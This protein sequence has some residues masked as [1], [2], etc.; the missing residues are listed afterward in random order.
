M[1]TGNRS[2][3]DLLRAEHLLLTSKYTEL[4]KNFDLLQSSAGSKSSSN[5]LASQLIQLSNDLYINP[6]YSD[7]TYEVEGKTYRGHKFV[8]SVRTHYFADLENKNKIEFSELSSNVFDLVFKWMYTDVLDETNDASLLKIGEFSSKYKLESLQEL[9]ELLLTTRLD[10]SNC[11]PIFEFADKEG[12]A[13]LRDDCASLVAARW[14]DF[15]KDHFSSLSATL[16]FRL[17]KG[18]STNVLNSIIELEREDVLFLFFIENDSKL[19]TLLNDTTHACSALELSVTLKSFTIAK[20]L[21]D[22]GADVNLFYPSTNE[23]LLNR[24][25]ISGNVEACV[26]LVENSVSLKPSNTSCPSPLQTI[27]ISNVTEELLEWGL[28][29][30]STSDVNFTSD[31][32]KLHKRSALGLACLNENIL[33]ERFIVALLENGADPNVIDDKSECCLWH[34]LVAPPKLSV[35]QKLIDKGANVDVH[36]HSDPLL[37]HLLSDLQSYEFLLSNGAKINICDKKGSY[38]IHQIVELFKTNKD[39]GKQLLLSTLTHQLNCNVLNENNETPIHLAVQT[40]VEAVEILQKLG[41][42]ID[43]ALVDKNDRSVLKLSLESKKFDC[44]EIILAGGA[45]IDETNK[46]G[47]NLLLQS[48]KNGLDDVCVFLLAHKANHNIRDSSGASCLEVALSQGME[49]TVKALCGVGV[50]VNERSVVGNGFGVLTR[51]ISTENF[52]CASLLVSFGC[53]LESWTQCEDSEQSLLHHMLDLG[54]EKAAIFLINNGCDVNAKK[55]FKNVNDDE[56]QTPL[57]MAVA[58]GQSEVVKALIEKGAD[59]NAQDVDG[60]TACHIA[61]RESNKEALTIL[62]EAPEVSFISTRDKFG[63]TPLSLAISRRDHKSA[64]EIVNRQPHAALQTNGNGENLLHVAVRTN[65]LES[66]LFLLGTHTDPTRTTQDSTRKTALHLSTLAENELIMRN[67]ILAGCVIDARTSDG[68][69]PLHDAARAH[70]ADLLRILLE[71]GASTEILDEKGDTAFLTSVRN[72]S[73]ACAKILLTEANINIHVSN[74]INQTALHICASLPSNKV[75]D[76]FSA[77]DLCELILSSDSGRTVEKDF[78]SFVESKDDLGN[79]ALLI[80]YMNGNSVVCRHLLR[81]GASMGARNF[82]GITV[83]TYEMPTKQLLFA[84]LDG[85]ERE[86]R[87][88]DGDVCDCGV[89]FSITQRKH[90]CRH[91]GRVVCSNCSPQAMPIAK[92]GE[93]K[94]VRLCDLCARVLTKGFH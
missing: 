14:N 11:V 59:L 20:Q 49:G 55:R 15:T 52:G 65:D 82:E 36:V 93:E 77:G 62:L 85:L 58:W 29:I 26:F 68:S 18:N 37:F 5:G 4:K 17:L 40:S 27:A 44:A 94:K 10:I 72:G 53:D 86:P 35:A 64:E 84:L 51:A 7:L 61:V 75:E 24:M 48:V 6:K 54:K 38:L 56:G 78:I 34:T 31:E 43:W 45:L 12:F 50:N 9:V 87:W 73:Y 47:E 60:R 2:H 66:V 91:C 63:Q 8:L 3:F 69:T 19:K 79:T 92:F 83:F 74:K 23:T 80:A 28:S 16:L 32:P 70:R 1:E 13:K 46:A 33:L 90:H 67:L 25:I 81:R 39:L 57:H 22:H 41:K 89:K 76:S 30:I 42:D 71:N 21:I 88:S